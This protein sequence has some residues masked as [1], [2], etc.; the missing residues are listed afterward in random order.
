LSWFV[1]GPLKLHPA[2]VL[3]ETSLITDKCKEDKGVHEVGTAEE[4]DDY[5]C[6]NDL[7]INS[8]DCLKEFSAFYVLIY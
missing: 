2:F 5:S 3:Y 4:E 7:G 6:C 1:L 8:K